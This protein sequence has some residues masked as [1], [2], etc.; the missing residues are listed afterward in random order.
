M[1][2]PPNFDGI[3]LIHEFFFCMFQPEDKAEDNAEDNAGK[4]SPKELHQYPQSATCPH[5]SDGFCSKKV[6]LR[7]C[8]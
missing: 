6:P 7:W 1:E 4:P 3:E 5:R 8:D 2:K